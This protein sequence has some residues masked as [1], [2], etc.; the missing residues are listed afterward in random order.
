MKPPAASGKLPL[1]RPS[2]KPQRVK[3]GWAQTTRFQVPIPKQEKRRLAVLHHYEILDTPPEEHFDAITTLAA[4]VCEAP[5]AL[6]SLVDS[7]RQWFKSKVGVT[8]CETSRDLAF[9]AHAI[10]EKG[11]FIVEDAASDRRFASNPLVTSDPQIRFYAGAPLIAPNDLILGTL[12]VIDRV[13]RTLTREQV[14]ALRALS[15]LVMA[16]LEFR[17]EAIQLKRTLLNQQL[18]ERSLPKKTCKHP[19]P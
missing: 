18:A 13:P 2:G 6:V 1:L 4:Q 7:N 14:E 15:R 5:I 12:C 8:F 3:V 19:K 11:L 16:L 10:M 9:C 17:R